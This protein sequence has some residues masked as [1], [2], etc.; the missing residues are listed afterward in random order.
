M[1]CYNKDLALLKRYESILYRDPDLDD[2]ISN[3]L[4]NMARRRITQNA[5][6]CAVQRRQRR[7]STIEE[8]EYEFNLIVNDDK[9]GEVMATT[10]VTAR[11]K[12]SI[13]EHSSSQKP[14]ADDWTSPNCALASLLIKMPEQSRYLSKRPTSFMNATISIPTLQKKSDMTHRLNDKKSSLYGSSLHGRSMRGLQRS[15]SLLAQ[16]ESSH[17]LPEDGLDV[18]KNIKSGGARDPSTLTTAAGSHLLRRAQSARQLLVGSSPLPPAKPDKKLSR[19]SAKAFLDDFKDLMDCNDQKESDYDRNDDEVKSFGAD[20]DDDEVDPAFEHTQTSQHSDTVT[21][22]ESSTS[23]S[24]LLMRDT[25]V[26]ITATGKKK[27]KRGD[28]LNKK[29]DRDH[30]YWYKEQASS[31]KENTTSRKKSLQQRVS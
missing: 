31:K 20:D 27:S 7:M 11:Y 28:K 21:V 24:S 3:W 9:G 4:A 22:T 13:P 8:I 12:N 14:S 23:S 26:T 17:H 6:A 30:H 25:F 10:N 18:A 15:S 1:S 5:A 19:P 2:G 29:P 16:R